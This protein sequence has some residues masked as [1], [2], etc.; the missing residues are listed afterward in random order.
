MSN[1]VNDAHVV[2]VAQSSRAE[3]T[4]QFADSNADSGTYVV[5]TGIDG[6][7]PS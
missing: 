6:G 2:L 1:H 3:D 7:V 5:D 4:L